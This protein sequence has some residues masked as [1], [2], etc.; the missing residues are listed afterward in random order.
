MSGQRH[1]VDRKENAKKCNANQPCPRPFFLRRTLHARAHRVQ[2]ISHIT[3]RDK[4]HSPTYDTE[5]GDADKM[6][7]FAPM[8][9]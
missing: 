8:Q 4:I 7:L 9:G 1:G 6:A 5:H 2:Y 3:F